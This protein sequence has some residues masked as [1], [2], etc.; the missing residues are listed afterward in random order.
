MQRDHMGNTA[1]L[2]RQLALCGPQ[3]GLS[4]NTPFKANLALQKL[5]REDIL[6]LTNTLALPE[7][8]PTAGRGRGQGCSH[9]RE[10]RLRR[11]RGRGATPRE[12]LTL[13]QLGQNAP[14]T[15]SPT[16]HS[17]SSGRPPAGRGWGGGFA[18]HTGE[19]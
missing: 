18:L 2:N 10:G 1:V 4:V 16:E 3:K 11:Q 17:V 19:G 7:R 8:T 5:P 12:K 13:A 14:Q 15:Q 9:V 6:E